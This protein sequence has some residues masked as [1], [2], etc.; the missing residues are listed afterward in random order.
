MEFMKQR[1]YPLYYIKINAFVQ[2]I[3]YPNKQ[4]KKPYL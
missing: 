1:H 2:P 4:K 3:N